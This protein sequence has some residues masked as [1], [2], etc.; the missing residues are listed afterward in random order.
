MGVRINCIGDEASGRPKFEACELPATHGSFKFPTSSQVSKRIELPLTILRFQDTSLQN[1]LPPAVYSFNTEATALHLVCDVPTAN[2]NSNMYDHHS[3]YDP[4][5][6]DTSNEA[7]WGHPIPRWTWNI[8][9]VIVVRKDKLPLYPEHVQALFRFCHYKLHPMFQ[10]EMGVFGRN[11]TERDVHTCLN[12]MGDFGTR[13]NITK[14]DVLGEITKAK[15]SSY[16]NNWASRQRDSQLLQV[17]PYQVTG[18]NM[19]DRRGTGQ[20]TVRAT[21]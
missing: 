15:F 7:S 9:S 5:R 10:M 13:K 20:G 21:H 2:E 19:A 17:N 6:L 18:D 12:E 3:V 11:M 16:Y 4:T 8:G 14:E 1:V